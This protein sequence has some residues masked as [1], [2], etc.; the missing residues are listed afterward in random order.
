MFPF[1]NRWFLFPLA[2]ALLGA[3][4]FGTAGCKPPEPK[5]KKNVEVKKE[6]VFLA[7]VLVKRLVRGD[8]AATVASTGSVVPL[9]S[10]LLRTEEAGR[11]RFD[12]QWKSGD[13]VTSGTLIARIESDSLRGDIERGRA[14]VSLQEES[15]DI[16]RKS[17]DNS[18]KEYQT[19]QDLYSRGISA[20]KDVDSAE[21]SMQRAINTFRQAEINLQ[22]AQ[23]QLHTLEER[24]ERLNI[25]AP[26]DGLLVARTT[27]DGTK[28]FTTA[29]GSE[30]ITDY[31]GRL[32]SSDF[33]IAGI[34]DI[35]K[36]YI[37][38]DVTSRDIDAIRPGQEA[39]GT[40]YARTEVPVT[41]KVVDISRA[42]SQDTRAF[43]VDVLADNPDRQLRPGMFGRM[44]V[45]VEKRSAAISIDKSL[46]TRRNNRDV[47]FVIEKSPETGNWL[48]REVPIETGLE[49]RDEVEVTWGL[50]EG[51]AIV[52]RGFEVLQDQSPV[53][54]VFEDEA[55]K[56]SLTPTPT[57]TPA[58]T[59]TPAAGK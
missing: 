28:P 30:T 25:T 37:R 54:P 22:K 14:D 45:V 1:S 26:Y 10:R 11:L 20:R 24:V 17:K 12:K 50:K 13:I 21:L 9:Q 47:V 49:G 23:S 38:L 35:S 7:P 5:D 8:V 59:S 40:I 48:S 39:L 41:G 33:A 42:T 53:A 4:A 46:I 57:P 6:R 3:V 58:P 16:A 56:P 32:V 36:V 29:F 15:L 52:T 18:I 43:Q 19:I 55:N 44:E 27:M 2:V 51:D 34:I 31:E